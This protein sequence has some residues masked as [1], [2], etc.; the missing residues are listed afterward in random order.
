MN[1]HAAVCGCSLN[2]LINVRLAIYWHLASSTRV[3]PRATNDAYQ[4]QNWKHS[5]NKQ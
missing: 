3:A 5:K 1:A 4:A 2:F